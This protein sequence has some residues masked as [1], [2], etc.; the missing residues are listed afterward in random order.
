LLYYYP[1]RSFADSAYPHNFCLVQYTLDTTNKLYLFSSLTS[2]VQAYSVIALFNH[3]EVNID[4]FDGLRNL[5]TFY[6]FILKP[7][8]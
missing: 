8:R 6:H 2:C 5:F 3:L 7:K 4:S 1:I